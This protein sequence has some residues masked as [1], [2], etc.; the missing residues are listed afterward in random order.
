MK[1]KNNEETR[2]RGI[3]RLD[4][5]LRQ[6]RMSI[7]PLVP[8]QLVQAFLTV[9]ANEGMTLTEIAE[10]LGTNLSTASRQL[11]DLS[12]RNRKMEPG[13]QLVSR[14]T[15]PTNLRVNRYTLTPKGKLLVDELVDIMET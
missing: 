1:D 9:A 2:A 5:A 8:T 10:K 4:R 13:Y 7:D 15:D 11:L 14:Q 12:D 3:K 6:V